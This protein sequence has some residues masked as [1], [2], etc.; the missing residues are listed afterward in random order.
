M[1]AEWTVTW[2]RNM[3]VLRNLLKNKHEV[4]YWVMNILIEMAFILW[5]TG[6]KRSRFNNLLRIERS[7]SKTRREFDLNIFCWPSGE[8]IYFLDSWRV[9]ETNLSTV[10][11]DLEYIHSENHLLYTYAKEPL[12][13]AH[14]SNPLILYLFHQSAFGDKLQSY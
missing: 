10:K 5:V 14:S 11:L 1:K 9:W 3:K 2:K 12:R 13:V 7:I 4:N 6:N 8:F